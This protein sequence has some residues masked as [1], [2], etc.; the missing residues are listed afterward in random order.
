MQK[1]IAHFLLIVSLIVMAGCQSQ[2][3]IEIT[4]HKT[5]PDSSTLLSNA[6]L[7]ISKNG[8]AG[9]CYRNAFPRR[10]HKFSANLVFN[11]TSTRKKLD[12]CISTC[13]QATIASRAIGA[14]SI[15]L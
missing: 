6:E 14:C 10:C 1:H 15:M 3:F 5:T 4:K 7:C 11:K 9:Q 12:N 13:Q 2:Q 8:D